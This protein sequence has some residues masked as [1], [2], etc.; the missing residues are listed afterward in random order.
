MKKIITSAGLIALTAA[1][2]RAAAVAG[3]AGSDKPWDVSLTVRGFYDDN[4]SLSPGGP[5]KRDTFGIQVKPSVGVSFNADQTTFGARYTYDARYYADRKVNSMDSTHEFNVWLMHQFSERYSADVANTFTLTDM[6]QLIDPTT[7]TTT[8][9][10]NGNNMHNDG[11]LNFHARLTQTLELVL[12][13]RNEFYDYDNHGAVPVY[14]LGLIPVGITSGPLA[15]PFTG[16]TY[17]GLL[18]R[19]EHY[20][21]SELHWQFQPATA[22]V[23][24]YQFEWADY[25]GNEPIGIFPTTTFPFS[26]FVYSKNLSSYSH[27]VYAGFN[28]SFRRDLTGTLRVGVQAIDYYNAPG[29]NSTDLSPYVDLSMRYAYRSGSYAE[30]GFRHNRNAT[31]GFSTSA[32]SITTDQETSAVYGSLT[33]AFTPKIIGNLSGSYQ[34]STFNGGSNDG[35]SDDIF[36]FGTS[37]EYH[38]NRHLSMDVGYNY[39]K[40]DS[41]LG[42]RGYSRN[43][44][45]LGMTATY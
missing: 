32:T 15:P 30:V 16:P 9:R 4:Y 14:F 11:N 19:I 41:K 6:P 3:V 45:F 43:Q 28:H 36:V 10:S 8:T 39:D 42:G 33:H 2:T 29:G 24:G 1:G 7:P 20:I 40:V 44:V 34:H 12:G 38:F 27:F 5:T 25:T 35:L 37:L 23:L 18:D 31:D 17:S 13:Y 21:S 22:A 26:T